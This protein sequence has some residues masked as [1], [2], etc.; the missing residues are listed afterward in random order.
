MSA[1]PKEETPAAGPAT[2]LLVDGSSY[3]Y[4][5]FHAMPELRNPAGEHTGAIY[6]VVNMLRRL[7]ADHKAQARACVFD[8]KGKTFR[9]EAYAEYK[10]QRAPMPEDL[11]SQIVPIHEIVAAMGWPVLAVEGV[12]ADDV[13]ATLAEQARTAG[14]RCVISTGDKDLAQL[15][16][17]SVTLVNTMSNEVLD[18]EGVK[19]KF[20]VP[21]ELIVDYLTLVGD[22]VDNVPGVAKVGPKTA[23]KWISQYGS[24]DAV[25]AHAAEIGGAVGENLRKALDWLPK[26]RWLLTVKRD[27]VLPVSLAD[28]H[29]DGSDAARLR[30][31]YA[32][33][34]FRSWLK[35]LDGGAQAGDSTS[36]RAGCRAALCAAGRRC[37]APWRPSRATSA[38]IAWR[39]PRTSC[40]RL[41]RNSPPRRTP[42]WSAST[43]RPTD[44]SR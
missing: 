21:P 27:C 37:P 24:L 29:Q 39:S 32:R 4:R 15:V 20:G 33:Y 38:A 19:Q 30:E 8:A 18:I 44:W 11:V 5:A 3:L 17:D 31:L 42:R 34:G 23:L 1:H 35:E 41:P 6:G 26:A 7:S 28:L 14:M 10:A 16:N 12:E 9:D 25:V 22:A 2:L 36:A 43:P 40:G 13:I